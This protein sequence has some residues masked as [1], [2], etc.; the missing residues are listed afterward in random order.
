MGLIPTVAKN[1]T[2]SFFTC[3]IAEW[4]ACVIHQKALHVL[5]MYHMWHIACV[6]MTFIQELLAN[7]LFVPRAPSLKGKSVTIV[8]AS[9]TCSF[10]HSLDTLWFPVFHSWTKPHGILFFGTIIDP[11]KT[12]HGTVRQL[13]SPIFDLVITYFLSLELLFGLSFLNQTT[14]DIK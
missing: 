4:V 2:Q 13:P 6:N 14:Q 8:F 9:V 10:V 1:A 7:V 11:I 3:I 5:H 12:L